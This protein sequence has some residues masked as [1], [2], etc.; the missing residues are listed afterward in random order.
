MDREFLTVWLSGTVTRDRLGEVG[1][2]SGPEPGSAADSVERPEEV[3][4]VRAVRRGGHGCRRCRTQ[5]LRSEPMY[6]WSSS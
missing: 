5:S 2:E 6:P 3:R 1:G 4:N